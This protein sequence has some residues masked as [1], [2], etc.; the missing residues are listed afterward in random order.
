LSQLI[1]YSRGYGERDNTPAQQEAACFRD[2]CAAVL[3][4]RAQEKGR[5]WIAAAFRA[6]PDDAKHRSTASMSAAIGT[7]HRCSDCAEP[8]RWLGFDIDKIADDETFAALVAILQPH[9]GLVWTT[10]SHTPQ[11]PRCRV[12]V[13]LDMPGDRVQV[14]AASRAFRAR[15]DAAI[16]AAGYAPLGWDD[17]CDRPEQPL[18]LPP[19]N[20]WAAMLEGEPACLGALAAM[21]AGKAA[22]PVE[23]PPGIAEGDRYAVRALESAA[24]A[25][26]A[27]EPG[28]L[29]RILNREAYGIGGFVGAGRLSRERVLATVDALTAGW[30]NPAKT[31]GTI[32]GA[33][34][35]GMAK[36]RI[37]GLPPPA[38]V[39]ELVAVSMAG[40]LD[41]DDAPWPHVMSH[42]LPRRVVTLLGGHGGVGKSLLALTFAAHVAAGRPWGPLTAESAR[43]VFLSF[44]DEGAVV[45]KRLKWIIQAYELPTTILA[46]GSLALF[47]GSDADTELALESQDGK[48]LDFT[49]MMGM[50][51]AAVAGAGLV[52]VDNASDTYG[53]N[54]NNRLQ[55]RRFIRRLASEAK[56]ND[57]AVLLLA[58]ID[59][60]AAKGNGRGNNYSGS[61]QWH[62]SVRSR[63]ALVESDETGIELLHEKANYGPRHEPIALQRTA[64]GILEPVARAQVEAAR[65]SAAALMASADAET[66]LEVLRIAAGA[67]NV[68]TSTTGSSTTWS[69][70]SMLPEAPGWM[71]AKAGKRRLEMALLG[72]ERTGAIRREEYRTAGRHASQRWAVRS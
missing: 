42:F 38:A 5:Q 1:R 22:P 69:V 59:K 60:Q 9:S 4:D 36:P 55:V 63:L 32:R 8:R 45:R 64:H 57:G 43:V 29:N 30:D 40:V 15:I 2:F 23:L 72:L 34:A 25:I 28:D 27:A 24:L 70:L 51:S 47:D 66:V 18:Y 48:G 49:P 62:N 58:H 33:L 16:A 50:V 68:P 26:A 65:E 46:D 44:E 10:H 67:R 54:E 31:R 12:L 17:A 52:I 14:M 61:T 11:A 7:P 53:G 39:G 13:E 41:E 3:A 6:A 19:V 56:A 37:D 35:S 71:K 20:G 21:G